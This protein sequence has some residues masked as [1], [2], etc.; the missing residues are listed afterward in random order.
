MG[1]PG[2]LSELDPHIINTPPDFRIVPMLFEGPLRGHP[3]TLTPEPGVADSWSVSND[4][5]TYLFH[6]REDARWSNG[7]KITSEDF[8]F[9]WR[10][11]LTPT[12]GSQYTFLMTD[13]VGADNFYAG[14]LA[15][16]SSVGFNAPTPDTVSITQELSD[17]VASE[18]ST[19]NVNLCES[20]YTS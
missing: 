3:A 18:H 16:Y 9:S 5:K 11:A 4:G 19:T 8:M 15:D 20:F 14:R 12:L 7:E 1:S 2:E 6:I 10:R 17:R 13:V